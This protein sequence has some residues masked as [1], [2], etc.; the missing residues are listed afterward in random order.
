MTVRTC[1]LNCG[2]H[3]DDEIE[4]TFSN[5]ERHILAQCQWVDVWTEEKVSI[6]TLQHGSGKDCMYHD[7]MAIMTDG[8]GMEMVR[9]DFNPSMSGK[10]DRVKMLAAALINEIDDA[11]IGRHVALAKTAF[12]EGAM[13]A[14]KALTEKRSK[15]SG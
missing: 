2:N 15:E 10:V 5:G 1:I 14:V 12:E 6:R 11:G 7:P 4:V 13:W 3:P 8:P 9:T